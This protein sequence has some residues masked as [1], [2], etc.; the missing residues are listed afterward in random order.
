MI[1]LRPFRTGDLYWLA[2]EP[3]AAEAD[4]AALARA[5]RVCIPRSLCRH[6]RI[7]FPGSTGMRVAVRAA[8][9]H[10]EANAP[11]AESDFLLVRAGRSVGIWWWDRAGVAHAMGDARPYASADCLPETLL[12][13]PGDGPRCVALRDGYEAQIWIDGALRASSWRRKPF[14][15]DQ[16]SAFALSAGTTVQ[17]APAAAPVGMDERARG[18]ATIVRPPL[19][20]HDVEKIAQQGAAVSSVFA[21]ALLGAGLAWTHEADRAAAAIMREEAARAADP[22]IAR[23]R[24]DAAL[25]A[26]FRD[27]SV[28]HDALAA[29]AR[30]H[31][32]LRQF[33]VSPQIW[34]V[35]K[36]KLEVEWSLDGVQAPPNTIASAFEADTLF[37]SVAPKVDGE[38]RRAKLSAVITGANRGGTA[39]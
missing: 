24:A 1:G 34:S 30:G 28:D 11:F 19:G 5:V 6:H 23:A 31:S 26:T 17:A 7:D 16:W 36:G 15:D 12:Q 8:R 14:T 37:E 10:A 39:R 20:P 9:L 32:I 35:R 38:A 18:F 33:D 25:L 4:R 13:P 21:A 2:E 29:A 3:A 22:T 27:Q